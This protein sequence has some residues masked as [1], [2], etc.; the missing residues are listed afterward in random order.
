MDGFALEVS[1]VPLEEEEEY[2]LRRAPYAEASDRRK[3]RPCVGEYIA[4]VSQEAWSH[5]L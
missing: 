3:F 2:R 4:R 1:P 5:P